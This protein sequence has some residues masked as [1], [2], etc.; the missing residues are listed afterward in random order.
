[1]KIQKKILILITSVTMFSCSKPV[2]ERQED[3]FLS[4]SRHI[5]LMNPTVNNIKIFQYLTENAIFPLPGD[6]RAVGV[7]HQKSTYDFQLSHD[8]I[9][10][11]E[12]SNIALL[13]IEQALDPAHLFDSNPLS[14]RFRE[15]FDNSEGVIFFGGSDIPPAV[16]GEPVSL[17]T[18]ITDP[19]RHYLEVSMLFHLLG[20]S[21]NEDFA[22]LLEE[23]SDYRILGI[24]LGM[25][26]MNVATGGTLIQDIPTEL[27][28]LTTMDEV[29]ALPEE[30]RHRNYYNSLKTDD[31]IFSD[32]QH[33]II[34]EAGS[35]ME[36]LA[37]GVDA[38]PYIMSSHHQSLGR[39]GKGWKVTAWCAEKRIPEAIEHEEYPHVIGV[40]FHP[41]RL[42]IFRNEQLVLVPGQTDGQSYSASYPGNAGMD[43][44]RNFWKYWGE[45][46]K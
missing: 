28:G 34:P 41:E 10:D 30:K 18:V 11:N 2:P 20:G 40:Q 32:S 17:L 45:T 8:Y 31:R 1:M 15:W 36:Q 27:Y 14:E 35:V 6:Y 29:L 7:Y 3:I 26:S 23:R 38:F 12:I 44:H 21:Q 16:Y 46:Y 4:G 24:C 13:G 42:H 19:H 43:F 25:Q 33:P 5:L 22:P 37:G 39:M 9:R